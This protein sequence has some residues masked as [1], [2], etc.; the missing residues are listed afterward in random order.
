MP[1]VMDVSRDY[2]RAE[3]GLFLVNTNGAL[4]KQIS[5]VI[6][7]SGVLCKTLTRRERGIYLMDMRTFLV[8]HQITTCVSVS[9]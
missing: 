8:V 6:C 7:G 4:L 5:A 9:L 1:D 3:D 2:K